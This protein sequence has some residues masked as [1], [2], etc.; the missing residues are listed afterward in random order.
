MAQGILPWRA[1]QRSDWYYS[2][3]LPVFMG[4]NWQLRKH[5]RCFRGAFHFLLAQGGHFFPLFVLV[6]WAA[7]SWEQE[8]QY[9]PYSIKGRLRSVVLL[10]V[11]GLLAGIFSL[12][13]ADSRKSLANMNELILEGR[14]ASR[15]ASLPRPLQRVSDFQK[16]SNSP[17]TLEVIN[18]PEE[19]PVPQ[20][21]SGYDRNVTAIVVLFSNGFRFGCVYTALNESPNCAEY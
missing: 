3:Q 20:P 14:Q 21:A 10:V 16:Y 7:N 12:Y 19:I 5:A 6:R 11:V 4:G 13:S 8:T 2:F 18:D 9:T 1:H 15:L 17:Y